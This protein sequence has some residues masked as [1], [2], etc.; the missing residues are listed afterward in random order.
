MN[1]M[2]VMKQGAADE[3]F[4]LN[5]DKVN[6]IYIAEGGRSCVVFSSG[7]KIFVRQTL[8]VFLAKSRV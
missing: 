5:L 2:P 8:E 3:E 1:L 6:I 4:L 7:D